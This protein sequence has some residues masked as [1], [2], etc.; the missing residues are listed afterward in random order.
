MSPNRT[1]RPRMDANELLNT[2]RQNTRFNRFNLLTIICTCL[3]LVEGLS[4]CFLYDIDRRV[5]RILNRQEKV[6][7]HKAGKMLEEYEERKDISHG[8]LKGELVLLYTSIPFPR[9]FKVMV[10]VEAKDTNG[11]WHIWPDWQVKGEKLFIV[12]NK[13]IP[14]PPELGSEGNKLGQQLRDVYTDG[15]AEQTAKE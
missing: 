11:G 15:L 2:L 10:A 4:L 1:G 13:F 6:I 12:K 8:E 7:Y 3:L 14:I 9:D 5:N